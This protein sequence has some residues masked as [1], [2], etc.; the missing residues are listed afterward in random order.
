MDLKTEINNIRKN[1]KNINATMGTELAE[2]IRLIG[3]W[4]IV[5]DLTPS[6]IRIRYIDRGKEI[7]ELDLLQLKILDGVEFSEAVQ[8]LPLVV[9][10]KVCLRIWFSDNRASMVDIIELVQVLTKIGDDL[11]KPNKISKYN[12]LFFPF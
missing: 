2:R 3:K 1:K 12:G 8:V 4:D 7:H 10:D 5:G 11:V 6:D 9:A